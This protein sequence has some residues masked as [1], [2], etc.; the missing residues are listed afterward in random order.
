MYKQTRLES[1]PSC[2]LR[3]LPRDACCAACARRRDAARVRGGGQHPSWVRR[4]ATCAPSD[5]SREGCAPPV[6]PADGG[7]GRRWCC[8]GARSLPWPWRRDARSAC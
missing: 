4:D 3:A 2:D 1:D 8:H 5:A 7:H 6:P